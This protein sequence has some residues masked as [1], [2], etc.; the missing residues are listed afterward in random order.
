MT[1]GR[2]KGISD[3][4]ALIQRVCDARLDFLDNL[5]TWPRYKGGWTK[6]VKNVLATGQAWAMGSVGPP[7][8]YSTNMEA[9]A[10]VEDAKPAPTKAIAD[11]ST[12]GGVMLAGM[13]QTINS[14]KESLADFASVEFVSHILLG[15]TIAGIVLTMGG[16]L[17]RAYLTRAKEDR[18][19]ALGL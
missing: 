10:L 19:A 2:V 12:G 6:R 1:M 11:T 5:K 4:D 18:D 17:Y 14:T 7:V 16:L 13:S 8:E 15:L 3:H 9:K